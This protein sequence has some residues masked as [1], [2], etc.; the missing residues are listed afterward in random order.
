MRVPLASHTVTNHIVNIYALRGKV[1]INGTQTFC[2]YIKYSQ[3]NVPVIDV[4][5][6]IEMQMKYR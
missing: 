1:G 5:T 4:S 3:E 2:F 6:N